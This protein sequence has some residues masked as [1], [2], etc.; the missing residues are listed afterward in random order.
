M[1]TKTIRVLIVDDHDVVRR[2]LGVFLRAFEDFELVGEASNG[3][4]AISMCAEKQPNVVLMDIVMPEMD[5]ITATQHIHQ[6]YPAIR[7]I[8]LTSL[9]DDEL[10][11]KMLRAGAASFILKDTSIDCL[12]DAIRSAGVQSQP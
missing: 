9:K 7:V 10:V 11:N 2:G 4:E 6:R 1:H 8:A 5:G 12:A 3:L